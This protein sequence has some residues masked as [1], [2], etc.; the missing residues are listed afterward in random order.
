MRVAQ[1]LEMLEIHGSMFGNPGV[2]NPTLIWDDSEV[3][4]I[5]TG[6]PGQRGLIREAVE[7]AG[8]S[9]DRLNKIILTH[10]DMDHIGDLGTIVAESQN[11][12]EVFSHEAEKPYIQGELISIKMT[13][14]RMAQQEAM[15]SKLPEEKRNEIK[16]MYSNIS[17]KVDTTIEDVQELPFCGGYSNYTYSRLYTRS[18]MPLF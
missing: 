4:L 1:G 18:C 14:E 5:D 15:L 11:P 16:K 2:F 13:P 7:K 3:I 17:A 6:L 12:I 9:F 8:V 10:Q